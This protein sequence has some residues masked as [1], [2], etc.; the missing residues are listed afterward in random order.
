MLAIV[1][2]CKGLTDLS[3]VE[4]AIPLLTVLEI[5]IPS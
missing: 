3:Q 5:I 2:A 4:P 1:T